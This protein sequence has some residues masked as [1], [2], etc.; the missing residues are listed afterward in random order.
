MTTSS[1]T[2]SGT[3]SN[4]PAAPHSGQVLV[5]DLWVRTTH[6]LLVLTVAGAWATRKLPGDWFQLHTWLGYST[7]VLVVTRLAWGFVGTR[8]ARFTQ[9]VRGP[10]AIIRYVAGLLAGRNVATAGHNPLGAL[11]VL[12]LLGLLLGQACTGLFASDPDVFEY[13]PLMG[14]VSPQLSRQL[15]GWHAEIAEIMLVFIGLHVLAALLYLVV[16][17]ENLVWPMIS[18]RKPAL[19]VPAGEGIAGS[20]LWFALVIVALLGLALAW[21]VRSAPVAEPSY[22]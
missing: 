18:G 21:V 6:W 14:Y 2:T 15:T 11:S 8:H 20:R 10:G 7:F 19:Q 4:N 3:T 17:R 13:G 5:W 1:N 12:A 16:K 9:F 22:F